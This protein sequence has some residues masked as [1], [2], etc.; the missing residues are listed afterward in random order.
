MCKLLKKMFG[1][2][3]LELEEILGPLQPKPVCD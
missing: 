2:K 1:V 3:E